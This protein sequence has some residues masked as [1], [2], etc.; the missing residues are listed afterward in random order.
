MR[1]PVYRH[2]DTKATFLG[3]SFPVEWAVV[4][5]AFFL[6]AW[7]NQ[8]L[9]GIVGAT[10]L[11]AFLRIIGYGKPENFLQHWVMFR[12]RRLYGGRFSAAVRAPAPRF[13]FGGY[14]HDRNLHQLLRRA[15]ET[16]SKS[17]SRAA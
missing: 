17:R 6:G 7:V 9:L 10:S 1:A 12:I 16:S 14:A 2:L 15:A 8:T 3:L 11:Y 13:P 5:L 4:L